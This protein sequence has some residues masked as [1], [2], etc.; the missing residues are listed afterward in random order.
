VTRLVLLRHAEP[1]AVEGTAP[2]TG[3]LSPRGREDARS[4]GQ[5]L[6]GRLTATGIWTS[7]AP[8]AAETA[9]LAFPGATPVA[10]AELREVT[11]PW[12]ARPEEHAEALARWLAGATVEGWEPRDDVRSRIDAVTPELEPHD[13]P[14]VVT[15]G[16]LLTA[17]LDR[18]GDLEDPAAFWSGLGLPDAWEF[19]RASRSLRR[20][21]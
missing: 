3:G 19:D 20:L 8:R 9:A 15:H 17:W 1:S 14:V 5:H 2:G 4:L 11:K 13:A 21:G 16:V 10:R 7:P 12:Y 6:A 18:E